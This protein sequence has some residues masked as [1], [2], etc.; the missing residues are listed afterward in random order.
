[1]EVDGRVAALRREVEAAE[2]KMKRLYRMV[3]D[4]MTDLDEILRDR[5]ARL[6]EERDGAKAPSTEYKSRNVHQRRSPRS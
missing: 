6:K 2:D 4:G 1:M 3:E 5:L